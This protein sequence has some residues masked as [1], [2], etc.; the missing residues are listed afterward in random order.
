MSEL[1]QEVEEM[2]SLLLLLLSALNHQ[3]G[4]SSSSTLSYRPDKAGHPC[5]EEHRPIMST[6]A[7]PTAIGQAETNWDL[8][9]RRADIEVY[10]RCAHTTV[11][12]R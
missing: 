1:A 9:A 7:A 4:D 3:A 10:T 12:A 11:K 2:P 5:T 6:C 8:Y